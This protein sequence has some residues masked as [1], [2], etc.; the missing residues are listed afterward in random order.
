[1]GG[2]WNLLGTYVFDG[3]W[4]EYVELSNVNGR[5]SADAVKFVSLGGGSGPTTTV[6]SYVHNDHLGTPQVMTDES[7]AEV[8][9]ATYDP[10]GRLQL[11]DHRN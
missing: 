4:P 9:R 7:G 5:V 2:Q 6:L 10:F 11:Q 8:W 3:A 1:L